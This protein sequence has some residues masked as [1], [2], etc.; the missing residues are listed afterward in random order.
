M[1]DT[2]APPLGAGLRL[3]CSVSVSG[4]HISDLRAVALCFRT[5]HCLQCAKKRG[6]WAWTNLRD[7][8]FKVT[9]WKPEIEQEHKDLVL[10]VGG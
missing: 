5:E 9:L 4:R 10:V 2:P 6:Y 3:D 8:R 1:D 7:M